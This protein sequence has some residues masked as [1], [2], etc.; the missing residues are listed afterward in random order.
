MAKRDTPAVLKIEKRKEKLQ[1]KGK[2]ISDKLITSSPG[3]EAWRR[4]SRNRLAIAGGV[5]FIFLILV[6]VLA[7]VLAPE[8]FDF[9]DY[10]ATLQT[11]N[12]KYLFGTDQYGRSILSRII[13]GAR[14]SLPIG[15]SCM[16]SNLIFGGILGACAAFFGGK[17]DNIIMRILDVFAAVPSTLMAI[18]VAASLGTGVVN[19]VL[20]MTI[21]YIPLFARTVRAAILTVK[22]ND[23]IEAANAVG[24]GTLRQ[25]LLHMIPNAM[26]PVIVQATFNVASSILTVSGLSY[27]GLGIAPPTPEWGSMLS[28][29]RDFLRQFPHLILFP[30]FTIMVTVLS[31]NLFGD[32][33]RDA[34]D[35]RLK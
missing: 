1:Q 29:G 32:G 34:L 9:Q 26:G 5:I 19:L 17:T 6:A 14:I 15:V 22:A 3:K 20:A 12:A 35:P 4:F 30:G 31:L 23:Y 33:L 18:A 16:L 8:G 2:G 24:V 25:I 28:A 7:P 10:G 11:P 21:S 13:W 27:L